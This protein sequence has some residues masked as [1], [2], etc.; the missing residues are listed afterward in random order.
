MRR[1]R[2]RKREGGAVVQVELSAADL[3]NLFGAIGASDHSAPSAALCKFINAAL[4]V[5]AERPTFAACIRD[6]CGH[7]D[8]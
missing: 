3:G 1:Y 5:T 2:R 4:L 6:A 7:R 8:A